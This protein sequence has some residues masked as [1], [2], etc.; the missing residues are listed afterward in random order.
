MAADLV[1]TN[2][3]IF[4]GTRVVGADSVLITDGRIDRLGHALAAPAGTPVAD[5]AGGTLL[6]GLI[7]AHT[8]V[9]AA[10][11]LATALIFGVTTELDLFCTPELLADL[12]NA[13]RDRDDHADLR[14]A[15]V[16]AT[17]PG[18][19][20]SQLVQWGIYPE[21]PTL[22][23]LDQVESFVA[24]RVAEGSDYLKII[25]EDGSTF[26]IASP[27]LSPEVVRA[28]VE[29]AHAAGLR[30]VA[31]V[32]TRADADL[33]IEAG[34]DGLAHLFVDQPPAADFAD[35]AAAAGIF[36]TP[37]LSV[38]EVYTGVRRE[39]GYLDHPSLAP[40]LDDRA[41]SSIIPDPEHDYTMTP[42]AGVSHRHAFAATAAL[43]QAGVPILAGTDAATGRSV[44]GFTL[45]GELA[46]LVDAGL[47]PAAA[48]TAATAAPADAYELTDRGRI[49]PGR[50]ADLL[51]VEG[52]PTLDI[53]ATREISAVWKGGVPLDRV[54]HTARP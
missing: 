38:Y 24:D 40:Y 32:S 37:T 5:G 29:A 27:H 2:V 45:H 33:A 14:S 10:S 18:G 54:P 43:H 22:A 20:P 30:T 7:D 17:A 46:A 31:H 21:F 1:I 53:T 25:L 23:G 15:G 34:V 28:L 35:R 48:L 50:R 51:L 42:P 39:L 49:E 52:D 13:V 11:D 3:R 44:H 6:P 16:G 26:G 19:H 8:H 9:T 36:V 12:R 47:S 41:R 4:D